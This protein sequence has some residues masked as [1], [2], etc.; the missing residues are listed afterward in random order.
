MLK[1]LLIIVSIF[2]A[3]SVNAH[4]YNKGGFE[5]NASRIDITGTVHIELTVHDLDIKTLT[6]RTLDSNKKP[7]GSDSVYR[8]DQGWHSMM[9]MPTGE[10][11]STTCQSRK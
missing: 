9:I 3:T 7:T 8:P 6:C 1:K 2:L 5:I 11:K 10:V 4:E